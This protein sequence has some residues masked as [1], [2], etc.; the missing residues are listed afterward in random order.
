[1]IPTSLF[2]LLFV[3]AA[4][5]VPLS[6]IPSS[7]SAQDMMKS[8]SMVMHGTAKYKDGFAHFDY[9]NP[10]APKGG[11]L[12]Q[13]AI[14]TFDTLNPFIVKGTPAPGFA[15][16]GNG[17]LYDSL[18]VQSSDEAFSMYCL[19]CE[20]VERPADN[21][22]ITFNLRSN[23]RWHDGKPITT[24]DVIWSFN[25]MIEHGRPFYKAYFG[26]V[27][28]V[29]AESK[30]RLTFTFKHGDNA[31]LP[32]ILGQL[33]ILPKHYWEAEINDFTSTTLTPPLGSGPYKIGVVSPGRSLSYERVPDY[34]AKDLPVSKGKYNFDTIAFE[35]FRDANVALEAFFAG[36]YDVRE[37][38]TAK[39]WAT[40]YDVPQVKNGDIVKSEV[41]HKRPQGVQ[42]FIYNTRRP[43]FADPKVREALAYAFDFEWS[44]KQFAFGAYKRSNSYFAN[45]ELAS[46][47]LPSGTELD[48]LNALKAEFPNDIPARVF[49]Q[50]YKAPTADGSGNARANLRKAAQLLD[51]AGWVS[52]EDGVRSKDGV[53]LE[54]EILES[55]PQFER[56]TLPFIKNLKRL[57]V[58]ASF[59]VIDSAQYTNR[60]QDFD[61]DM[62]VSSIG[63]SSSP[64]NEQREY[65]GSGKADVK[66]SRNTMGIQ[67]PAIDALIEKLIKAEDR[68]DLVAHTK[69]LDRLL[70]WG[71]YLIPQ[72]HIDHWRL[73]WDVGLQHPETLSHIS[74]LITSTWWRTP[75]PNETQSDAQ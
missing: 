60:I 70:L 1:M 40:A 13:H 64:G 5:A 29:T 50:E 48:I 66:G 65:W 55:N 10:D 71:H 11:T 62:T 46:S 25:A 15:I 4:F 44:N 49:T 19:L 42:G 67:N 75:T 22:S 31:E 74:P 57:G 41:A 2:K 3:I 21:T 61:F 26:D 47:G 52:G 17:L 12:K 23:A 14:G 45:S 7:G 34:W 63:Q 33:T 68:K 53:T 16:L 58:Q 28:T 38:N 37:E 24:D 69:A 51:D 36:Q 56:W 43:V 73:A 39:L 30:T 27:E 35:Y 9:V 72:W 8:T 6:A 20:S 32:L 18:M 54:F 59:R